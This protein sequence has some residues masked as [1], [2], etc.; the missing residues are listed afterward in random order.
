MCGFL[1]KF[2]ASETQYLQR[3]PTRLNTHRS[4]CSGLAYIVHI[5]LVYFG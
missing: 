2:Y 1:S 3:K 5:D 4:N